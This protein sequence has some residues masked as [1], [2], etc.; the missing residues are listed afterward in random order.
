MTS[1]SSVEVWTHFRKAHEAQSRAFE[2]QP[3]RS[4]ITDSCIIWTSSYSEVS[5][6][7]LYAKIVEVPIWEAVG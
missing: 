5:P 7:L 6:G 3:V 4:S 2:A 1:R